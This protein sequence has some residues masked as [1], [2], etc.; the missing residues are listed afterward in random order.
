[1]TGVAKVDESIRR[2][3]VSI[4]HGHHAANVNRLT[5]KDDIDVV[6]GMVRYS[7]VPVSLHPRD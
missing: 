6:T 5:N 1:L 2:G 4:P 7:G 3:A